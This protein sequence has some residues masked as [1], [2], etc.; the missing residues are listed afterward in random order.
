MKTAD[1]PN[2]IAGL[3]AR[4]ERLEKMLCTCPHWGRKL[5]CPVHGDRYDKDGTAVI[6][7]FPDGPTYRVEK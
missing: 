3:A 7:Y 2:T 6:G 1:N 5:N 4:L